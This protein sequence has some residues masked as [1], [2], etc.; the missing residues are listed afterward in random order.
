M[1]K[2]YRYCSIYI[3]RFS[4][5]NVKKPPISAIEVRSLPSKAVFRSEK[6]E[7]R[8]LPSKAVFSTEKIDVLQ[9]SSSQLSLDGVV[10]FEASNSKSDNSTFNRVDAEFVTK[11]SHEPSSL[12][13]KWKPITKKKYIL[14]TNL[15]EKVTSIIQM[16]YKTNESISFNQVVDTHAETVKLTSSNVVSKTGKNS[17]V[18]QVIDNQTKTIPSNKITLKMTDVEDEQANTNSK[19]KFKRSEVNNQ[20]D[21]VKGQQ[22][23]KKSFKKENTIKNENNQKSS[24]HGNSVEQ[25]RQS[26]TVKSLAA[27]YKSS[28]RGMQIKTDKDK[29]A[30]TVVNVNTRNPRR[31]DVNGESKSEINSTENKKKKDGKPTSKINIQVKESKLN[32]GNILNKVFI[33]KSEPDKDREKGDKKRIQ[34]NSIKSAESSKSRTTDEIADD[35]LPLISTDVLQSD[36]SNE[37]C[38]PYNLEDLFTGILDIK[39][40]KWKK[41]ENRQAK[42]KA[43]SNYHD[44]RKERKKPPNYFVAIQITNPEI[45]RGIGDVQTG[46]CK[47]NEFLKKAM[48]PIPTLHL[49]LRVACLENDEEISRMTKALDQCVETFNKDSKEMITLDVKDIESFRNEVVFANVQKDECLTQVI[50][51]SDILEE[52]CQTNYVP[53]SDGKGFTPH[54][55]IAKLTKL[56]FKLKKNIKKIDPSTYSSYKNDQFGKQ[57]VTCLQLCSMHKPKDRTGYYHVSHLTQ[58]LSKFYVTYLTK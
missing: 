35:F 48:I 49:T 9:S 13:S 33:T 3:S 46:M 10:N 47:S 25:N 34:G 51:L 40:E 21:T 28:A 6:I 16:V 17:F 41:R 27:P 5:M 45:I 22:T 50:K 15:L 8:S 58:M 2:L 56:P 14:P 52:C 30:H 44:D 26:M 12:L 20:R 19:S 54:I 32:Q 53:S 39:Y 29:E 1:S 42:K 18:K 23:D 24:Q 4:T 55:T 36:I 31:K 11:M 57:L 7:V 38:E 37:D 43:T